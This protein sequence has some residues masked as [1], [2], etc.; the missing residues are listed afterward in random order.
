MSLSCATF[1]FLPV[2]LQRLYRLVFAVCLVVVPLLTGLL[3]YSAPAGGGAA[4]IAATAAHLG[5]AQ[6]G[7]LLGLL[8]SLL[9]PFGI[10]AMVWLAVPRSP[11]LATIGGG[12]ALLGWTALIPFEVLSAMTYEMARL[13]QTA[14]Y[15]TLWDHL[16]NGGVMSAY[17]LIFIIGHLVGPV[18]LGIALGRARVIPAWAV[19]AFV[20]FVPLQAG[21]FV[22]GIPALALAAYAMLMVGSA[23]AAWVLLRPAGI[24]QDRHVPVSVVAAS[25]EAGRT[26]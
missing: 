16:N 21:R 7:L 10:I 19:G 1:T 15:V 5:T 17:T 11:W 3:V 12:I 14:A 8:A 4:N 25:Q 6:V 20:L 23:A 9:F 24:I 18:L 22:L 2:T 13:G 26:K